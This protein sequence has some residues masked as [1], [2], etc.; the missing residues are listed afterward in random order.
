MK[1]LELDE[2]NSQGWNNLGVAGGGT[3]NGTEYSKKECYIKSLRIIDICNHNAY[4]ARVRII[5]YRLMELLHDGVCERIMLFCKY[6][7]Q[8]A[9]QSQYK[10]VLVSELYSTT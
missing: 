1:T 7:W 8:I 3:V 6:D 5:K 4:I 10:E 2:Q 9:R